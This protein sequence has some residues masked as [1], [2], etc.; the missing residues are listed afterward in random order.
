MKYIGAHVSIAGGVE[1]APLIAEFIG[2]RAFSM[3]TANQK[4]WYP[5][6]PDGDSVNHFITNMAMS[7]IDIKMVLPHSSYLINLASSDEYK[8]NKSLRLFFDEGDRCEQLGLKMLN[9]HPGNH[10]NLVS[11]NEAI[12]LIIKAGNEF[13][14]KYDNVSLIFETTAGQG[15][16]IGSNFEELNSILSG[17]DRKDRAGVCIDTCHIFVAGYDIASESGYFETMD[18]FDKVVGF[19]S[20]KGVHLNDSKEECGSKKDRHEN[21]GEGLIGKKAFELIM[22]DERFDGIPLV[23]ETRDK[24]KWA[25]EIKML[26]EMV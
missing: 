2:A 19:D 14:N 17:I 5:K 10:L 1:N 7:S 23:L 11:N 25:D 22:K 13:L 9:I 12:D 4:C 16:A 8:R 18:H 3:F 15:T 6:R 21:I 20:L 24:E 26:Y